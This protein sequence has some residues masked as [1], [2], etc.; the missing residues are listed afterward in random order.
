MIK[1][2]FAA[3]LLLNFASAHAELVHSDYLVEGDQ[4]ATLDTETGI[5]WLK[6][7]NTPSHTI[8]SA[9]DAFEG[10]RLPTA[11]DVNAIMASVFY[12]ISDDF[13][14]S[15]HTYM[16]A[17]YE[18]FTAQYNTWATMMGQSG[19]HQGNPVNYGNYLMDNGV[20]AAAG[21]F[22]NENV[23]FD[24]QADVY[25]RNYNG[26]FYSIFLVSDGG[27]TLSSVE[28]PENNAANP[29]SPY[30]KAQAVAVPISQ[31]GISLSLIALMF[32]G[33]LKN[34]MA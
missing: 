19:T 18:N 6:L 1:T 13:N 10:W 23:L 32:M 25:T 11:S 8:N 24:Y 7:N 17:N 20:G 12:E 27:V 2:I 3:L 9:L 16:G 21:A 30:S 34:K 5:E 26:S 31:Y 28:S 29:N 14:A 15:Q 4:R 22:N 33:R